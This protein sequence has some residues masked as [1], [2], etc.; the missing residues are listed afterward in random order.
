MANP[1]V[2][3]SAV[4]VT[5]AVD[6]AGTA[7]FQVVKLD[8][9][10]SGT[11]TPV[12][13]TTGVPGATE[14]GVIVAVKPGV[15]VSAQVSG[16]V[17][18]SGTVSV[19]GTQQVSVV[20]TVPVVAAT[21]A[22]VLTVATLLGTVNVA[23]ANA[24]VTTT[25]IPA[26]SSTGIIVALKPGAT[27]N[28]PAGLSVS[29]QN[30]ASVTVQAGVSVTVVTQLGTQV[31]SVVP[32]VSVVAQASGTL[33]VNVSG[34]VP[35]TTQASVSVAGLPVW[36]GS[37]ATVVVS[38]GVAVAFAAGVSVGIAPNAAI[39]ITNITPVTTAASVSVS[40]LPVWLNPTQG[41]GT[42]NSLL[43]TV[44]VN[45]V[46]GGAGG[47]SVTTAGPSISATGQV[48]WIAGGQGTT[49]TPI[50]VTGTVSAG[51]GT[52]VVSVQGVTPVTTQ[53]SVSVTGLP[54]WWNNTASVVVGGGTITTL[55]G[56]IN[57]NVVAGSVA[58]ST[59]ALATVTQAAVTGAVA[60]LA[61]TQTLASVNVVNSIV[62]VLGTQIVSVVPGISVTIQQG[63][64]VSAVVS[65]TVSLL[66]VVPVT[67]AA[68]VSVTA[69]P[70][71]LNPT[72]PVVVNTIAAGFSVNALVTGP[73]SISNVVPVTTAA[74]VSVT[75]FP[76]WLNPTQQVVVSGFQGQSVSAVVSG[77]VT[78]NISGIVPVTTAASVSVSGIPVWLNPTQQIVVSGLAGHSVSGT[79]SI[80]NT[81][82]VTGTIQNVASISTILGTAVVSVVPGVAVNVTTGTVV[83]LDAGRTQV[84]IIVTSTSVG[85]S[86]TIMLMTVYTGIAQATAGASFWVVPAG[87][88]FRILSANMVVQNSVTTSPVFHR[89]FVT[90]STAAPTWTSTA[91]V[92]ALVAQGAVSAG[93]YY[94][95]VGIGVNDVAAGVTV[96]I[97]HT[98]GTSGGSIVQAA[99]NGYLFP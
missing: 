77:T 1:V 36:F 68:S 2:Q 55:L 14:T 54:V 88:T 28:V 75:G 3:T 58:F 82:A 81:V 40:G 86:G 92:A 23:V 9:G 80:S 6:T 84:Q 8:V 16:T 90:P 67:T 93:V 65:G 62:T 99:V 53:A 46:A 4:G 27:V 39:R 34:I 50:V 66:N 96:A 30:G 22:T 83:A 79:L 48:V 56:T 21:V 45:V 95:A 37:S 32:G 49:A 35:V 72:Q 19:S 57:A 61:P 11:S 5:V 15:S 24:D 98:I 89:L 63:A 43:G 44:A 41:L 20:S 73:V 31:V 10:A 74:S 25:G 33:T 91:P 76:V 69:L 29:I 60:W 78:N 18:V 87:K 59:T 38:D 47:G 51:A 94:S 97:A 85:I 70:V 42:I 13:G 12:L 17:A 71:W 26:A 7:A 64:S 52:T